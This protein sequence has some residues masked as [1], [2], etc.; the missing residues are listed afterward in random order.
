MSTFSKPLVALAVVAAAV[1][2]GACTSQATNHAAAGPH[3][4]SPAA[5][6]QPNQ[7]AAGR[8]QAATHTPTPSPRPAPTHKPAPTHARVTHTAKPPPSPASVVESYFAAIN[9]RDYNTAYQIVSPAIGG[10]Y[11]GFAAAFSG[12]ARDVV[13]VNSV[14]GNVVT[15]SLTAYQTD[16]S[17]KRYHGTYT[18]SGSRIVATHVAELAP[19]MTVA[20]QNAIAAAHEYLSTMA[21][22]RAGLIQQLASS[23]GEGYGTAVATFAVDHIT[24]DWNAEAVKS[25]REYLST[26]P[27]SRAGLIEQLSSS[28]GE[29]FT[30]A[31][32]TYAA[33][34]VGLTN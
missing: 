15:A 22:S 4:S 26:Q 32:A 8:T 5:R 9:R 20:E 18:V 27:F 6:N 31:Q 16:G 23:A 33:D 10:T 12:T 11:A 28:A 29:G 19:P 3:S 2:I 7:P 24:V 14:N 17:Q 34:H 25:A 13:T 1:T 30:L 21:F